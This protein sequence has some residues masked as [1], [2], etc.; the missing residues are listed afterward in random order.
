MTNFFK[1]PEHPW[2]NVSAHESRATTRAVAAA[3]LGSLAVMCTRALRPLIIIAM[4]LLLLG[5]SQLAYAREMRVLWFSFEI[6]DLW[7]VDGGKGSDKFFATG[8]TEAYMPPLV[9]G[10]ACVPTK[11]DSC[12][13]FWKPDPSK[14]FAHEG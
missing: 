8:A 13:R 12:A 5:S 3:E 7:I 2:P 6:P 10:Q 4:A 1:G 11:K 14:E 9:L